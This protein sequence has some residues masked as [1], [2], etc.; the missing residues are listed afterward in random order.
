MSCIAYRREIDGLRA[1]AVLAVVLYHAVGIPY[2]GFVGVDIF[3]VISGYLITALLLREYQ[4][5]D[6]IDIPAF[7]ARRV[8]RI[9]PAALVVILAVLASARMF[10]P[11]EAV[12]RVAYSAT[13]SVGFVA[14]IFF[15]LATGGYFAPRAEEMPLLH[16]WSLSV[17]EQFYLLWPALLIL[18]LRRGRSIAL[19]VF[20]LLAV[21]SFAMAESLMHASP[22]T[23]FYQMPARFWELATGG[24]IAFLPSSGKQQS[25]VATSALV[26]L[27]MACFIPSPH[28]PGA[29]A[30]PVVM[31]TGMLL[32]T[33]HQA[34]ELGVAGR[35]LRL[36]PMTGIGLISYSLYLWHWPLLAIYRANSIGQGSTP[37]RLILCVLALLL[38]IASYRYVEQ[39]FRRGGVP[40]RRS[41]LKGASVSVVVALAAM[42]YGHGVQ[43]YKRVD[44][45]AAVFAE[46]D[47]PSDK[48]VCR[49]KMYSPV[50]LRSGCEMIGGQNVSIILWGDSMAYA[51]EP[52]SDELG[53]E[54]HRA[55]MDYSRAGC[56]PFLIFPE[57]NPHT[58]QVDDK[59]R[60]WN[61]GVAKRAKQA[62]TVILVAWWQ[63]YLTPDGELKKM[64][65]ATLAELSNVP[66]VIILGQ[67]PD[68][69][70]VV[71]RCIRSGDMDGCAMSRKEYDAYAAPVMAELHAAA[72]G[73]NNVQVLEMSAFFC[74]ANECPPMKDGYAMYWDSHH[75][76][77]TAAM[78]FSRQHVKELERFSENAP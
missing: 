33:I 13:A 38:A 23:S 41:I 7:Y 76:S 3:F 74:N 59:C 69:H 12:A 66:H 73:M 77:Q 17:E 18:F 46:N 56:G 71:G 6:R 47:F 55:A 32:W 62:N 63:A 61:A 19:R 42:A 52:L 68:M 43:T 22:Q 34:G 35:L 65:R 51:W 44:N 70:D 64:L 49:A 5:L 4:S 26:C 8:R 48:G 54:E 9:F 28:F 29:G 60:L 2:S 67:T 25:W 24:V 75:I 58:I 57:D 40:A 50:P 21:F 37:V 78:A 45:T 39:P 31:A 14:N 1:I 16:L 11:D 10:L 27:V 15:Q 72:F 20:V 53:L 30:L 36:P